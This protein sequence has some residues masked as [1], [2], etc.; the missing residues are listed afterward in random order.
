MKNKIIKI[1]AILLLVLV[2]FFAGMG[3]FEYWRQK[4][5]PIFSS[6]ASTAGFCAYDDKKDVSTALER[7][8]TAVF[9]DPENSDAHYGLAYVYYD[10]GL[11]DLSIHEFEKYLRMPYKGLH[12]L[13]DK[14]LD[15]KA[16]KQVKRERAEVYCFLG[17]I[18]EKKG[19]EKLSA[20]N[21]KKAAEADPEYTTF[22]EAWIK[23]INDKKE[24]KDIDFKR[25]EVLNMRLKKIRDTEKGT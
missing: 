1:I 25:L 5:R 12:N 9:L 7:L 15:K 24:K 18:Y 8:Y 3:T 6:M 21:Y 19:D 16:E 13:E 23:H 20:T 22:L 11:Y 2:S 10:Q 14:K 17:D 4:N